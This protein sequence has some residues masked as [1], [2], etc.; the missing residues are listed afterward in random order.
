MKNVKNMNQKICS[1]IRGKKIIAFYYDGGLRRIEPYC[2]GVT[3]KNNEVL[4]A[5]QISGYSRSRKP[6][7]WKLFSVSKIS[8]LKILDETFQS[9]RREY[10][11]KDPVMSRIFCRI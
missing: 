3:K 8:N 1:A 5:F 11:P 7:G 4:R 6:I 9:I 2:Y 10:N